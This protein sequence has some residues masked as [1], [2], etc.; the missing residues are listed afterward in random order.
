M[1][2]DETPG[3]ITD[4]NSL[5]EMEAGLTQLD[6]APANNTNNTNSLKT[7][8]PTPTDNDS[9]TQVNSNTA[10][11]QPIIVPAINNTSR[12]TSNTAV[13]STTANDIHA[14]VAAVAFSDI[15]ADLINTSTYAQL[16]PSLKV[17]LYGSKAVIGELLHNLRTIYRVLKANWALNV[18]SL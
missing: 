17:S 11:T 18:A 1:E 10:W 16:L 5:D 8:K 7:A 13:S 2:I 14:S 3:P 6:A 4:Y 9:D 12:Q 15:Q